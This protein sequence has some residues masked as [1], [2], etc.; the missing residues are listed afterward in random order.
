MDNDNFKNKTILETLIEMNNSA[1]AYKKIHYREYGGYSGKKS[2]QI[3]KTIKKLETKKW[4]KYVKLIERIINEY[5]PEMYIIEQGTNYKTFTSLDEEGY[6]HVQY[7]RDNVIQK[8]CEISYIED[9]IE[10]YVERCNTPKS[11]YKKFRKFISLY[12]TT[13][14]YIEN[15]DYENEDYENDDYENED[16]ENEDYENEDYEDSKF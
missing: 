4:N 8:F 1:K 6:I 14:E 7:Y 3:K 5:L 15:E 13:R 2:A 11:V 9:G 12:S 10:T 16:Y